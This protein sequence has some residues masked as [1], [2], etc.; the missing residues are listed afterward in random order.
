MFDGWGRLVYRRRRLVLVVALIVVAF[1][2]A[3][4]T[5]V[6]GKLQSSGGF[7]PPNSQSQR[8]ADLATAAFGRDA[9]DVNGSHRYCR[10]G[11]FCGAADRVFGQASDFFLARFAAPMLD[12]CAARNCQLDWRTPRILYRSLAL[13]ISGQTR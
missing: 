11:M 8:S 4:G 3:W 9:G 13:R 12:E 2:A 1:A 7:T 5:G 6:F 10:D